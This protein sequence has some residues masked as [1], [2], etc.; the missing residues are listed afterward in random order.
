M[1]KCILSCIAIL[2]SFAIL[3]CFTQK[4]RWNI[5][6]EQ[7]LITI[8]KKL[9]KLNPQEKKDFS[10][11]INRLIALDSF[12][13]TLVESK[14]MSVGVVALEDQEQPLTENQ[15]ALKRG[16]FV[17][18]KYQTLFLGKRFLWIDYPFLR[19]NRLE[20]ALI[21]PA[22]YK[23]I[24]HKHLN[25]FHHVLK[26]NQT[27]DQ[28]FQILTSPEDKRFYPLIDR[29][30]LFGILLG[31]GKDNSIL[32]EEHTLQPHRSVITNQRLSN[33]PLPTFHQEKP[34]PWAI[35]SPNF[36][37]DPK[38]LETKELKKIYSRAKKIVFWTYFLRNRLEVSLALFAKES[39]CQNTL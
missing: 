37:C 21:F 1:K 38:S 39:L 11:F 26:D 18:K 28:I 10:Y 9:E 22:L 31:F 29:T 35:L 32:Y 3:F 24:I 5:V 17:W 14:P 2:L 7:E 25:D 23:S 20:I 12:A 36:A 8:R 33:Q 15:K 16:Y 30:Y 13:Y 19:E 4:N 34:Y 27:T 6:S